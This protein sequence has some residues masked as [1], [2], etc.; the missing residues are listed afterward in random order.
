MRASIALRSSNMLESTVSSAVPE[1]DMRAIV[2]ERRVTG[3]DNASQEFPLPTS[4]W[5]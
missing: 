1:S 5:P 4:I 2:T 3:L